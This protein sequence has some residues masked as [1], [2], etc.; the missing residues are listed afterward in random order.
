MILR[1]LEDVTG[2]DID[3]DGQVVQALMPQYDPS[4]REVHIMIITI[5]GGHNVCKTYVDRVPDCDAQAWLEALTSAVI[6][7]SIYSIS[8]YSHIV[9]VL[10]H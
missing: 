6:L 4:V 9:D 7:K 2:M 1:K 5:E 8:I 3:G 10:G